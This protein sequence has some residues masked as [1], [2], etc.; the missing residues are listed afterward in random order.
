MNDKTIEEL[1]EEEKADWW[2]AG[3][4]DN[5]KLEKKLLRIGCRPIHRRFLRCQSQKG[6][7]ESE[8]FEK[9]KVLPFS[10]STKMGSVVFNTIGESVLLSQWRSRLIVFWEKLTNWVF[11]SKELK[12]EYEKCMSYLRFITANSKIYSKK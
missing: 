7:L 10:L 5:Y 4:I 3:E 2:K 12:E 8:G 11:E 6:V 1:V 9:C